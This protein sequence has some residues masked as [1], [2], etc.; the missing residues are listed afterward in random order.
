MPEKRTPDG[1]QIF[2]AMSVLPHIWGFGT[3]CTGAQQNT[4]RSQG[5]GWHPRGGVGG[6]WARAR[7]RVSIRLGGRGRVRDRVSKLQRTPHG[8]L[9]P[10]SKPIIN[11]CIL[12]FLNSQRTP[13]G[14]LFVIPK[15]LIYTSFLPFLNDKERP[16]G[17]CSKF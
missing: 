9:F 13:H 4:C 15:L 17:R 8:A 3:A 5:A 14:A 16:M 10:T 11:M 12:T 2:A 1:A 7:I 6:Q